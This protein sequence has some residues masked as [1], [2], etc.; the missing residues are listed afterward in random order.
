MTRPT[1]NIP[2]NRQASAEHHEMLS[3]IH[4]ELS[5]LH[6]HVTA[7]SARHLLQIANGTLETAT[8][9]FGADGTATRTRMRVPAAAV[10]VLNTTSATITVTAS[11]RGPGVPG[12]GAGA[13]DVPAHSWAC[14]PLDAQ[15]V[16][17]YGPAGQRFSYSLSARPLRPGAG[18]LNRAGDPSSGVVTMAANTQTVPASADR[19]T[20]T[21]FNNGATGVTYGYDSTGAANLMPLPSG[22]TAVVH[23]GRAVSIT[24]TG[25]VAF[26]GD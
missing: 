3:R 23:N 16:T 20:L 4:A 1:L 17:F 5:Q 2:T 8:A 18:S 14:L 19:N 10:T 13:F 6:G 21:L 7:E 12:P 24:G 9:I 22:A 15:E 26:I 11:S 25:T